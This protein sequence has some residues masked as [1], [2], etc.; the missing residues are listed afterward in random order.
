[1]NM[2]ELEKSRP[3]AMHYEVFREAVERKFKGADVQSIIEF[4]AAPEFC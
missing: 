3:W 2:S 4:L 1:M